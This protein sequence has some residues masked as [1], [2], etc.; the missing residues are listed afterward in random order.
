MGLPWCLL[1]D[2]RLRHSPPLPVQATFPDAGAF[3]GHAPADAPLVH[4]A[5]G[6]APGASA[7]ACLVDEARAMLG[8]AGDYA[9]VGYSAKDHFTQCAAP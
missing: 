8:F 1:P 4:A 6:A 7:A 3:E 2:G 9:A 5:G